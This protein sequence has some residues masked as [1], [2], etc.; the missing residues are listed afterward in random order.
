[1]PRSQ[2]TLQKLLDCPEKMAMAQ[3]AVINWHYF[4]SHEGEFFS[5]EEADLGKL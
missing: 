1:M 4:E 5:K 2:F 3:G